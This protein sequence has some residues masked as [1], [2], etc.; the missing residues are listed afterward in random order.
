MV[1]K[2]YSSS[3]SKYYVVYF[4]N[5]DDTYIIHGFNYYENKDQFD[6][7]FNRLNNS[8]V[9]YDYNN[10]SIRYVASKGRG[11]YNYVYNNIN[12]I[13]DNNNLFVYE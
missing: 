9:D 2:D 6:W 11:D 1:I 8:I 12:I 13:L 7:E 3:F 10:F 4:D 5:T